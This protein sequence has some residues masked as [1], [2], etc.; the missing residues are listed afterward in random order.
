MMRKSSAYG[1]VTQWNEDESKWSM[2]P[3]TNV[4]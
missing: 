1:E 3:D 2:I 4:S